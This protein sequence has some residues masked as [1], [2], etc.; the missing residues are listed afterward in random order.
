MVPNIPPKLPVRSPGGY[1]RAVS[2]LRTQRLES[3]A[4]TAFAVFAAGWMLLAMQP[5]LAALEQP[6]MAH[7]GH[8]DCAHC[9]PD[10]TPPCADGTLDCSGPDALSGTDPVQAKPLAVAAVV[11]NAVLQSQVIGRTAFRHARPESTGP[12][13]T[14]RYCCHL[15]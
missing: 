10:A 11:S 1:S 3:R 14:E 9:A 13:L 12:P 4:P 8:H 15:E 7:D 6:T 2:T 5:C